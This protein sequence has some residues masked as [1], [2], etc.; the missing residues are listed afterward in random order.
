M[1]WE[2]GLCMGRNLDNSLELY[3]PKF[4]RATDVKLKSLKLFG[5]SN[6]LN[7]RFYHDCVC[8]KNDWLI[9]KNDDDKN[10]L[11]CQKF[12]FII[13]MSVIQILWKFYCWDSLF[14]FTMYRWMDS[15]IN[16]LNVGYWK[17]NK[18]YRSKVRNGPLGH[19]H[20]TSF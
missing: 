10:E 18:Y 14:Q 2:S 19:I 12:F 4:L 3:H 13:Y 1:R 16:M 17:T 20:T 8:A 6:R 15:Q 7:I 9:Y 5:E 11:H